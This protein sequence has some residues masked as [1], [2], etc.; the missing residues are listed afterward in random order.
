[1]AS[2]RWCARAGGKSTAPPLRH[3]LDPS[4]ALG[5]DAAD[6]EKVTDTLDVWFDSGV[7][8]YCVL[9][10]RERTTPGYTFLTSGMHSW[11][12]G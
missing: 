4:G 5:D 8:H 3:H 7:S 12:V 9:D 10:D 11:F 2:S 6:Y 1:M